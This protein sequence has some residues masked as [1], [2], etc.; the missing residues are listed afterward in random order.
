MLLLSSLV[1]LVQSEWREQIILCIVRWPLIGKPE[2]QIQK[3]GTNSERYNVERLAEVLG[4]GVGSWPLSYLG[5]PL[6][7][8]P[9]AASFW[10][11]VIERTEKRL[12]SWKKAFLSGEGGLALIQTV[13]NSL[14]TCYLSLF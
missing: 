7:G 9:K 6:G 1:C 11:L 2:S 8:N 4:C 3:L 5:L 10:N 14:P 13:L 12:E